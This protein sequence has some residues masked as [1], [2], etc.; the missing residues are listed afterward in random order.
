MNIIQAEISL[1]VDGPKEYFLVTIFHHREAIMIVVLKY[2]HERCDRL[3]GPKADNLLRHHF[4]G[5]HV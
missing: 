5:T 4:V 3:N 2:R 1:P